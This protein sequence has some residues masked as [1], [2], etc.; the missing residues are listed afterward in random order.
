MFFRASVL[1][2]TFL[3][4]SLML[5]SGQLPEVSRGGRDDQVEGLVARGDEVDQLTIERPDAALP[6]QLS[7]HFLRTYLTIEP[8][9]FV[10]LHELALPLSVEVASE[11]R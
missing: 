1:N 10:A 6:Y 7:N 8:Q 5:S 9:R 3:F 11:V 2:T 4:E